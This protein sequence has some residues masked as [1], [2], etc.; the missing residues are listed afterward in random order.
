MIRNNLLL[1]HLL[2]SF[3]PLSMSLSNSQC[4]TWSKVSP[5]MSRKL[6]EAVVY[7]HPPLLILLL[8][9]FYIRNKKHLELKKVHQLRFTHFQWDLNPQQNLFMKVLE[10]RNKL[11]FLLQHLF[12]IFQNCQMQ[13]LSSQLSPRM[14]LSSHKILSHFLLEKNLPRIKL[15]RRHLT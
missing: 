7:L 1:H 4:S 9:P 10:L 3:L 14:N 15:F 13:L 8:M 12:L 5:S 2:V 11:Q 6:M